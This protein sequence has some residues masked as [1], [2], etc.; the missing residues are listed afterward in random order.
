[1]RFSNIRDVFLTVRKDDFLLVRD[2]F[3]IEL[4]YD[5]GMVLESIFIVKKICF[6]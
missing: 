2:A 3:L 4:E 1:M 5:C 6:L